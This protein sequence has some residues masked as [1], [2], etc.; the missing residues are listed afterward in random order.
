MKISP[1]RFEISPQ[2]TPI[3][4]TSSFFEAPGGTFQPSELQSSP[5]QTNST[6]E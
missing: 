6:P 1:T 4:N 2:A 5:H 3:K